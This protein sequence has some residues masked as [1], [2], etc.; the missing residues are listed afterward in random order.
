MSGGQAKEVPPR[1]RAAKTDAD[2]PKPVFLERSGYRQRRLRDALRMLPVLGLILWLLPFIRGRGEEMGQ[3]IADVLVYLF[4][5]WFGL[6]VLSWIMSRLL[7]FDPESE[8]RDG[9]R[10]A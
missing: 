9:D 1:R 10:E 2:A 5:V 8:L 4:V 6:I 7:R 3:S